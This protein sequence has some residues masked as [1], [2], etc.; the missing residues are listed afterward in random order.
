MIRQTA[1]CLVLPRETWAPNLARRSAEARVALR[2]A[3]LVVSPRVATQREK[4][5][6]PQAETL[7]EMAAR[8]PAEVRLVVLRQLADR[9][10]AATL[11]LLAV[12]LQGQMEAARKALRPS[13]HQ[14]RNRL[15]EVKQPGQLGTAMCQPASYRRHLNQQ[16][17]RPTERDRAR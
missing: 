7:R 16:P 14:G 2:S 8:L 11:D 1:S 4:A 12:G 5:A 17:D 10:R 13:R 9:I 3:A 15:R 6:H